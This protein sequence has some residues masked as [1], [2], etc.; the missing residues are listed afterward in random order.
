[1]YKLFMIFSIDKKKF[2]IISFLIFH[3]NHFCPKHHVT[4]KGKTVITEQE[5]QEK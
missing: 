3:T 1:M 4:N 2:M 5:E